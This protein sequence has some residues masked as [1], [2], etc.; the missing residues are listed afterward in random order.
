MFSKAKELSV[1]KSTSHFIKTDAHREKR[2]KQ[3]SKSFESTSEREMR[4]KQIKEWFANQAEIP[5]AKHTLQSAFHSKSV[6]RFTDYQNA[7]T[8]TGFR[9]AV[10]LFELRQKRQTTAGTLLLFLRGT[11]PNAP[12]GPPVLREAS[13][14]RTA[15]SSF[16]VR[17]SQFIRNF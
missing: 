8:A 4:L 3:R 6:V 10:L 9:N 7:K 1:D 11:N 2:V 14:L 15:A 16:Q 5:F 12:K 13:Q 17:N